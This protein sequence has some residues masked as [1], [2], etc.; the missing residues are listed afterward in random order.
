MFISDWLAS[1]PIFYNTATGKVSQNINDVI[2]FDSFEWHPEGLYNYI[3]FGYSVLEQTPLKNIKFLRHSS[4]LSK[5]PG[6]GELTV[7]YHEDPAKKFIGRESHEDDILDLL[8]KKVQAWEDSVEGEIVLPTSG[9]YDSRLLNLMIKDKSRI[10]SFTYGLSQQQKESYEVVHAKKIAEILGTKWEQIPLG[11][12]HKYIDEWYANYGISTHAHGMYHIEFYHK[13]K[14]KVRGGNPFLSGIIGDAWAG[15]VAIKKIDSPKDLVN[16][17]YS[18][19]L[20]A[21]T[22]QLILPVSKHTLREDYYDNNYQ[23]LEA[24]FW[25]VTESMRFKITLLSYLLRIPEY[26][27]YK[28]YAPFLDI[29]I[30]LGMLTLPEKRR[31]NRV[32]QSDFFKKYGLDLENMGLSAS[33]QNNLNYQAAQIYQLKP[34]SEKLLGE[35]VNPDYVKWINN[36]TFQGWKTKLKAKLYKYKNTRII[37]RFVPK[38][39]PAFDLSAYC[40]Y[41]TLYPL[42][43]IIIQRNAYFKH[44]Q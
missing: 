41:L 9:G 13:M 43:Q 18:H 22:K 25:S 30:A 26:F 23:K 10:R 33:H 8:E 17:G 27:G 40:A 37:W 29:D 44:R 38:K 21:D 14:S 11:K 2:D 4:S 15:N 12:Y 34:L 5:H 28:T 35:I 31:K 24:S 20:K 3:D 19:G 7:N 16:L 6:T 32:W 39:Y 42:Q 36:N 1:S